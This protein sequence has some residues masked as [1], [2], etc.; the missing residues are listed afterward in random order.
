[1]GVEISNQTEPLTEEQIEEVKGKLRGS[2]GSFSEMVHGLDEADPVQRFG[3]EAE[4]STV[5][6]SGRLIPEGA[7][8]TIA[9]NQD[10]VPEAV[11]FQ[12][13][14]VSSPFEVDESGIEYCLDEMIAK[15][16]GLRG[17]MSEIGTGVPLPIGVLPTF[18]VDSN[19]MDFVLTERLRTRLINDYLA[20]YMKKDDLVARCRD[21]SIVNYGKASAAGLINEMHITMSAATSREAALMYNIANVLSAPVVAVSANSPLIAG[22]VSLDEDSQIMLYEQNLDVAGGVPR[23]GTFPR[24]IDTLDDYFKSALEFTPIFDFDDDNPIGSLNAHFSTYW[25]W[26]RAGA[27]GFLRVELRA[28][29]KQPT[30]VEDLAVATFYVYSMLAIKEDLEEMM[31][32]DDSIAEMCN[33]YLAPDRMLGTNLHRAA[34]NSYDAILSGSY[35]AGGRDAP[36]KDVLRALYSKAEEYMTEHG[37]GEQEF[38]LLRIIGDRIENMNNPA[39]ELVRKVDRVGFDAAIEDYMRHTVERQATPYAR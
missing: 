26:V 4:Y 31:E 24:H 13:E 33:L 6:D 28:I 19:V 39:R 25:P 21:G 36:M 3:I 1:M 10:V 20:R 5:D 27:N 12:L 14:L 8:R 15:E 22:K 2:Y 32:E 29:S 34:H 38:K 35:G 9:K 17:T 18:P 7:T 23:V 11:N 16:E 37:V 30:L